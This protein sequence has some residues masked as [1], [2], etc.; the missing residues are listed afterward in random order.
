VIR[1]ENINKQEEKN[2]TKK[3]TDDD[4]AMICTS[5]EGRMERMKDHTV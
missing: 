3:H 4:D 1:D 5:D 2:Q